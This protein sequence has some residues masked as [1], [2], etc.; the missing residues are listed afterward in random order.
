MHQPKK[1]LVERHGQ[2][3]EDYSEL[4]SRLG[5]DGKADAERA[6]CAMIAADV[7]TMVALD[8]RNCGGT[9]KDFLQRA[10]TVPTCSSLKESVR[11]LWRC[12]AY[13][14]EPSRGRRKY[15]T[16]MGLLYRL[17]WYGIAHRLV[18]YLYRNR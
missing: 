7:F 14:M 13:R 12:R 9:K 5:R 18:W 15:L 1:A 16:V 10:K 11:D 8:V 2:M 3:I 6:V 4:I 17:G